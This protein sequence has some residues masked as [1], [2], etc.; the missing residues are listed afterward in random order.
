MPETNAFK[1]S[2]PF[3]T[4]EKDFWQGIYFIKSR[5]TRFIYF[6]KSYYVKIDQSIYQ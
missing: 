4:D 2:W 5:I 6:K 3:M 1:V